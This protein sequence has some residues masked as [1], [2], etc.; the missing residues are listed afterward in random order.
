MLSEILVSNK[1]EGFYNIYV[2]ENNKNK[3]IKIKVNNV[4]LPFGIEEYKNKYVINFEVNDNESC[5]KFT[6][7]INKLER[8]I[9][10]LIDHEVDIKSVLYKKEN[11]PTKCRAYIKKNKNKFITV[12]KL[13]NKEVSLFEIQKNE[14]YNLE[15]EISGIWKYKNTSGLY[16]NISQ[17]N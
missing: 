5:K 7:I 17:I 3:L 11:Y 8:N 6:E 10:N 15:L 9:I 4:N 2:E 16:I 14:S 13:N 12:Y 1:T